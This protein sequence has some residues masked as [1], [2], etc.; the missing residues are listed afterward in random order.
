[1]KKNNFQVSRREVNLERDLVL[2]QRKV[3][4][5]L[6]AS[7]N[8]FGVTVNLVQLLSEFREAQKPEI[9]EMIETY[10]VQLAK[11]FRVI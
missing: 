3:K 5:V 1:M 4:Q 8:V 10:K 11:Y 2:G 9:A 6:S 7:K